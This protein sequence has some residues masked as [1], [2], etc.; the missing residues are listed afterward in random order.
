MMPASMRLMR[1]QSGPFAP[2]TLIVK[3]VYRNTTYPGL[4]NLKV[5]RFGLRFVLASLEY[6]TAMSAQPVF[7]SA[8]FTS[9]GTHAHWLEFRYQE[10]IIKQKLL[11]QILWP[12]HIYKMFKIVPAS[13]WILQHDTRNTCHRNTRHRYA[14]CHKDT[15]PEDLLYRKEAF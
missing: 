11:S 13:W 9:T 7:C 2:S 5:L 6:C 10:K 12:K 1:S 15:L 3:L 14:D 8:L 4:P